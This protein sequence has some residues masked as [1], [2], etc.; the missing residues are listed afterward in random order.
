[1]ADV[2]PEEEGEMAPS[3]RRVQ[4]NAGV[5]PIVTVLTTVVLTVGLGWAALHFFFGPDVRRVDPAALSELRAVGRVVGEEDSLGH[6][7]RN[8]YVEFKHLAVYLDGGVKEDILAEAEQRLS[9][10]GWQVGRRQPREINLQSVT[11]PSVFVGVERF[12]E[13]RY[14]STELREAVAA[15]GLPR[16]KVVYMTIQA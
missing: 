10:S 9:R 4:L 1:M 2:G 11:W 8:S 3:R 5:L 13:A 16:G 14:V 7:W 12:E 15:T 6:E